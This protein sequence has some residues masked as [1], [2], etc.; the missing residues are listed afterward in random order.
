[1]RKRS[2]PSYKLS[3]IVSSQASTA[4]F[5]Q[6]DTVQNCTPI[7]RQHHCSSISLVGGRDSF[8][9]PMSPFLGDIAPLQSER[10]TTASSP[11]SIQMQCA[12]RRVVSFS[13][14]QM[15]CASRR[16]VSFSSVVTEWQLDP[17][18][19]QQIRGLL[20]TILIDLFATCRNEQLNRYLQSGWMHCPISGF[21]LAFCTHIH[22]PRSSQRY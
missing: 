13:S 7:M 10:H 11:Q 8:S 21:V 5:A 22:R 9:R 19:F 4:A 12:S 18:L 6:G 15:Q 14:I 17:T 20:P 1:M 2:L 16:V 3:V